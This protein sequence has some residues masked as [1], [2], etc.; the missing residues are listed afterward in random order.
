MSTSTV[1][2]VFVS[3]TSRDLGSYRKAI[4]DILV[5]LD[6][7]PV[8]QDHFGPDYRSVIAMLRSE[9]DRCDA[10]ICLVGGCY[11][12]EP[13]ERPADRPR[14]SYTQLEYEI[15]I[16]LATEACELSD[17]KIPNY[18]DTLAAAYA[19]TGQFADALKWQKKALEHPEA[20]EAAALEQSR[21]RLKLCEAREPYHEPKPTPPA[22]SPPGRSASK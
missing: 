1:P 21:Q 4:S 16:E 20:F 17:W 6:A 10:V 7:L 15:V 19:E 2:R 13:K 5:R 9:I 8:D 12:Y 14:R 18:L 3:G 11:G 22:P